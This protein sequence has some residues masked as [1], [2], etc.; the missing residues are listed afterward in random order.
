MNENSW[1]YAH[2]RRILLRKRDTN[3]NTNTYGKD[4]GG[5]HLSVTLDYSGGF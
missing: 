5:V 1:S 3:T 4:P 2:I